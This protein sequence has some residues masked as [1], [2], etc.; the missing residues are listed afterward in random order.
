MSASLPVRRAGYE[1]T[2]GL[3]W[4][5]LIVWAASVDCKLKSGWDSIDYR[6]HGCKAFL[7]FGPAD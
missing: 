5:E 3:S 7:I 6:A 4:S 1:L 2:E